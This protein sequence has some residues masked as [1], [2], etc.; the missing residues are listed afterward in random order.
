MTKIKINPSIIL[1]VDVSAINT[2]PIVVTTIDGQ[3]LKIQSVPKTTNNYLI[4]KSV[5][6][7]IYSLLCTYNIDTIIMEQSKLFTDQIGIHPDPFIL[8]NVILNFGIN[9][10]ILDNYYDSVKYIM[11]LPNYIWEKEVLNIH[12]K[13]SVDYY[14]SHIQL[15]DLT[16][17]C[18][19]TIEQVNGYKALCLS[20]SA[21]YT[22]L[23]NI[24]YCINR[25]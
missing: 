22:Q 13:Y 6:T 15:K 17:E 14:K 23:M 9:I 8:S 2:I 20:E 10:A 1:S 12:N 25:E 5:I 7:T 19:N 4:R 3:I 16:Q 18:I 21:K 24:K 11:E